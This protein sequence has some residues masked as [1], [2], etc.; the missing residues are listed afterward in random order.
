MFLYEEAAAT[1]ERRNLAEIR[2]G[3]LNGLARRMRQPEW[4]PDFGPDRPHPSAGATAIGARPILI[5]YN[6]N[7]ASNRLERRQTHRLGH[8]REQRRIRPRQ[9][10]GSSSSS[11]GIVQ[12][13]MNLTNYQR[14][15]HD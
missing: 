1:D 8:P 11:T 3:G 14:D 9:G 15:L 13:S 2:R 7:L 4:R 5:A 12:V 6:V 10:D